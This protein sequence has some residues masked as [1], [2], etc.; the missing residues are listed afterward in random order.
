MEVLNRALGPGFRCVLS[1]SDWHDLTVHVQA[2]GDP[3]VFILR[4]IR[5]PRHIFPQLFPSNSPKYRRVWQVRHSVRQLHWTSEDPTGWILN[6]SQV[7]G[8]VQAELA[9]MCL[10]RP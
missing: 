3:C 1:S 8:L 5:L 10:E 7:V 4:R 2:P 6:L 9:R